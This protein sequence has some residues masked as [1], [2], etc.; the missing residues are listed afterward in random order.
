M[1][2]ADRREKDYV[3]NFEIWFTIPRLKNAEYA[4]GLR[5]HNNNMIPGLNVLIRLWP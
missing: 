2:S 1:V 4:T 5:N 3:I